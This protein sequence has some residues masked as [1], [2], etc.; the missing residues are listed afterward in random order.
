MTVKSVK[1]WTVSN[2]PLTL[3]DIVTVS[4]ETERDGKSK[5]GELPGLDGKL[6]L[7]SITSLPSRVN[8]GPWGNRV[9]DIVG[10]VGE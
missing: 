1:L 2:T 7:G 10:T 3:H 4:A 9:S 6:G 8:D 5:D